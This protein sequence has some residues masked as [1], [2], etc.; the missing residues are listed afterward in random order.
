MRIK[1][2]IGAS[3]VALILV[4]VVAALIYPSSALEYGP[5]QTSTI[6]SLIGGFFGFFLILWTK[7]LKRVLSFLFSGVKRSSST[8]RG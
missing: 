4:A 1:E 7:P 8:A 3:V 2:I 5:D 6:L